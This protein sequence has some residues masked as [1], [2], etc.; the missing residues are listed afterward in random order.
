M[1][2][3][4]QSKRRTALFLETILGQPCSTGLAVKLQNAVT[5]ALRAAYDELCGQLPSQAVLNIDETL[6]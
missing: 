4:G 6:T 3:F 5:D 2:C 1:A